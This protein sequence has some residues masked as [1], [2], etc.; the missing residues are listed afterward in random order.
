MSREAR[1][2][3]ALC[4]L[5]AV[6]TLFVQM[7][8]AA[9]GT[10]DTLLR[11]L[12]LA[13]LVAVAGGLA[14][15]R[16]PEHALRGPERAGLYRAVAGQRAVSTFSRSSWLIFVAAAMWVGLLYAGIPYAGFWW[17]CVAALGLAW[18]LARRRAVGAD[19]ACLAPATVMQWGIVAAVAAAAVCVTL[20]VDRPD[21]DDA[22]YMS[23][24]ATL[25]RFPGHAI[26][27]GD[28]MY[29]SGGLPLLLPVYRLD[30]YEVL[31]GT[32]ARLTGIPHMRV[33]YEVLPPLF[34]AA[35]VFVWMK[36]V[37]LLAPDRWLAVL[38][39]L[40]FAVL[41]LGEAHQAY[42]NFAFVRL[43]QGKAIFATVIVPAIVYLA[44]VFS[45]EPTVRSWLALFAA[46]VSAVGFTS[47]ALFAAPL[48][49]GV[50]LA[51]QWSLDLT[52]TRRL[53]VGVAASAY[54]FA[55][56]GVMLFVTHGGH[57]FESTARLAPVLELLQHT[58]GV[59]S[60]ALLLCTLLAAWA[61]VG[62]GVGRRYLV[63]SALLFFLSVLNP[64]TARFVA[65]HLTGLSTYWRLT[66]A[67]PLPFFLAILFVGLADGAAH[68]RSKAIAAA[69]CA[70]LAVCA[71]WF[72]WRHGTLHSTPTN[73]LTLG[74]PGLKV[75]SIEYPVAERVTELVPA[76]GVVLAP[77]L[78]AT[79]LPTFT[80]HPELIGVRAVYLASTFGAAEAARRRALM[81]YVGGEIRT[82][83]SAARFRSAIAHYGLT[84]VVVKQSAWLR[85]I[86]GV[87]ATEGWRQ[88][89]TGAYDI[90][91]KGEQGTIR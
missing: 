51:S 58:W 62:A 35:A 90:W 24:P 15:V 48:T 30:T 70:I 64:Y 13:A 83:D 20:L 69:A 54:V 41:A 42:G 67:V 46:Q 47:S 71:L 3:A 16:L 74:T 18:I 76:N 4:V 23:I 73:Y 66:W 6:W 32:V 17:G 75:Y 39:A 68:I 80:H 52:S 22:F 33:A 31:V 77:E 38:V 49:A 65:D 91:L 78:V 56:A 81:E 19:A 5:Y 61:F 26:L 2:V 45:R 57:G 1:S 21:P 55:A 43:F 89:G 8:V 59:R 44:L 11:W 63:A 85:E 88:V 53:F 10:F 29:R 25:L 37:R 50:A 28:T 36:L 9:H 82:A 7:M 40:L 14:C 87:L 60:T 72:G 27:A 84:C 86:D 79:W 12:P 34:A